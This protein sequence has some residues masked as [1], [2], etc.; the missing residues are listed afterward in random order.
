MLSRRG[1][2]C[3]TPLRVDFRGTAQPHWSVLSQS[4]EM[5]PVQRQGGEQSNLYDDVL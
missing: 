2:V 1:R 3:A 5:E 4:H